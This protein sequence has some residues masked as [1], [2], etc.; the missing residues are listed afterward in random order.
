MYQMDARTPDNRVAWGGW[1]PMGL[2]DA[3]SEANAMQ[4]IQIGGSLAAGTT[5]AILGSIVAHGGTVLGLSTAM[6]TALVPIV[7]PAIA[8]ATMIA[9]RLAKGCGETCTVA[10]NYANEAE[11]ALRQ[12]LQAYLSSDR[13]RAA[14]KIALA[15]FDTI[16]EALKRACGTPALKAAGERCIS[17]RQAGACKWQEGGQCW[18]WFIGYRDP[19]ANDSVSEDPVGSSASGALQSF[20]SSV[21]SGDPQSL[22]LLALAGVILAAVIL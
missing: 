4:N 19:I 14:Q 18:N 10:S 6:T 9:M 2:G 12:N 16:W 1:F 20:A 5:T 17:D 13:T 3:Q 7:G 15:N 21:T 22:L 8:A 11:A